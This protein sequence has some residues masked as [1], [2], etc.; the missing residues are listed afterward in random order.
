[1]IDDAFEV[2]LTYN[3]SDNLPFNFLYHQLTNALSMGDG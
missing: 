2:T 1:M 3:T